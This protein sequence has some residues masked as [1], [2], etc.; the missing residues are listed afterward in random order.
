MFDASLFIVSLHHNVAILA[1]IYKHF[2]LCTYLD[3]FD[4][5][6]SDPKHKL[7]IIYSYRSW[8][9][10]P[11][12]HAI[13]KGNKNTPTRTTQ[14]QRNVTMIARVSVTSLNPKIP[15]NTATQIEHSLMG[16]AKL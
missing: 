2:V 5:R 10:S 8:R 12:F 6:L 4:A 1:L 7:H 3:E 14:T 16:M 13:P 11:A 9:V 15:I